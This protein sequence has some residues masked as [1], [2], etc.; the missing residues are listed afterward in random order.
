M[1]RSLGGKRPGKFVSP[2]LRK[3]ENGNNPQKYGHSHVHGMNTALL[4]PVIR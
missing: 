1:K 2:L 4:L 3:D